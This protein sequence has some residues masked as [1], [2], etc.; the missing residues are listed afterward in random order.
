MIQPID[1]A[2]YALASGFA[3]VVIAG[4]LAIAYSCIMSAYGAFE[5]DRNVSSSRIP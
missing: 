4:C 2:M 3:I 5:N 1:I